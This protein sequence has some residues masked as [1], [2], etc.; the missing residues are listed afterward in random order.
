MTYV[1]MLR[2]RAEIRAR[3]QAIHSGADGR[4]L[5][6]A[7]NT[8]WNA[9][10]TELRTLQSG[11]AREEQINS[12]ENAGHQGTPAGGPAG[13]NGGQRSDDD[14][15]REVRTRPYS[16]VRAAEAR[17]NG[18]QVD[19]WEAEC[20]QE[21]ARRMGRSPQGLF[22]P[23]G[24]PLD[25]SAI[26][27]PGVQQRAD[28][29]FDTTAGAGAV[30]TVTPTDTIIEFLRNAI[31]LRQAGAQVIA[32]L[33]G[34]LSIP[35]QTAAAGV[36]WLGEGEAPE[37]KSLQIGTVPLTPKT[38]SIQYLI[39]RKMMAQASLDVEMLAR[40]DIA[41]GLAVAIDT[42]GLAGAVAVPQKSPIG[43]LNRTGV[44]AT[45]LGANGAALTWAAVVAMESGLGAANALGG[46]L[47]YLTNSKVVG[48]AKTTPKVAGQPVY[49]MSDTR[50][51][52]GYPT[53]VTNAMPSNLTKGSGTNLSSMLFGNWSDLLIGMWGAL[54]VLL[55][56][57]T[58]GA[59]GGIKLYGLQ[60]VDIIPR[61]DESFTKIVDIVTT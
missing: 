50:E 60:D 53:L 10:Q 23:L 21:L 57:Y 9:L 61:H 33:Y 43:L 32:G 55:D 46:R 42:A 36:T 35:K 54:D 31:V 7:E 28:V 58:A 6:E 40:L 29:P 47:A 19:G 38:A 34:N 27:R 45:A 17:M 25:R 44:P 41:Q 56:P 12:I 52:N 59:S 24:L 16:I 39:T 11:I 37:Q 22:I 4:E 20:S 14:F 30:A 15:E 49:L 3:M 26:G 5:T 13:G 1:E 48:H 18:R 51:M 2:R 8:E